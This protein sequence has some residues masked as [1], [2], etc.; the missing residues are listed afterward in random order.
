MS[1]YYDLLFLIKI[2]LFICLFIWIYQVLAARG[3]FFSSCAIFSCYP[4]T[5][6]V[7]CGLSS[8]VFGF[9]CSLCGIV[10]L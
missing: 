10:I 3:V 9:S 1:V 8:A 6:V 7:A 2:L 5:L 4:W